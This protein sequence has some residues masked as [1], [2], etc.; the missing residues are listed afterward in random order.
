[1]I[2]LQ[3]LRIGQSQIS[4]LTAAAR[5]LHNM[6]LVIVHINNISSLYQL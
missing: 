1:M 4:Q 6:S 3:N 5:L 2:P